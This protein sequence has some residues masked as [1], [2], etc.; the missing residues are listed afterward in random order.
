MGDLEEV[1]VR[2]VILQERWIDAL[3]DVAHEQHTTVTDLAE[4]HDRHVVDPRAAVGRRRRDLAADR[5]QDAQADVVDVEA[6]IGRETQ[7]DRRTRSSQVAQPCRIAR[8]R[9]AHPRLEHPTD[10]V[11]LEQQR[12]TGDVVLVRM[13]ED[14][15]VDPPVPGRDAGV[16]DDHQAVR[17]GAAVDEQTASARTLDEDG[18][19]LADVE[20]RDPRDP[21]RTGDDDRARDR[22]A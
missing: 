14:D 21:G 15:G 3:L 11:A 17:I 8:S 6:I 18:V 4:Q 19:A 12:E 7:P 10:L 2:Q 9:A 22:H 16:E 13:A 20:D 5:P 1:D